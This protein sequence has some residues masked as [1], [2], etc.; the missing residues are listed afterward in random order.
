L[1][2]SKKLHEMARAAKKLGR[3]RAAESICRAVL[4]RINP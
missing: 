1:L 2:G 3:P 4:A